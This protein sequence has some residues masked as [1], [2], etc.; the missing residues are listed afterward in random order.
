[1]KPKEKQMNPESITIDKQYGINSM[2]DRNKKI[3]N[4]KNNAKTLYACSCAVHIRSHQYLNIEI[5]ESQLNRSA[6]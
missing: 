1:M 5:F 2:Q 4:Q 6:Y 3:K